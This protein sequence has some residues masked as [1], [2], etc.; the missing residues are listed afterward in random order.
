MIGQTNMK[1]II[2]IV[3]FSIFSIALVAQPSSDKL[4]RQGASFHDK[5]RYSEAISCYQQ[6]LKVNPSSMSAV[7]E[8][9]LSYLKMEDYP[10][11]IKHSTQ[12]INVGFKPLLVDAYVVK[13]TA[14]AAQ[15]KLDEAISLFT[16]AIS[17][18]GSEY[19]LHYNLGLAYYNKGNTNQALLHLR[20]AVERDATHSGAFLAYAYALNDADKWVQSFYAF[21]FFLLLEPNTKRSADAFREMYQIL[22][23]KL[24]KTDSKLKPEDGV[25]RLHLYSLIDKHRPT[26]PT[27]TAKYSFFEAASKEIFTYMTATNKEINKGVLWEFFVPIY[28]EMLES[29][30]FNTYCRYVSVAYFPESLQWWE[31]NKNEVDNFIEWFEQ[32]KSPDVEDDAFFEGEE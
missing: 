13:G 22:D 19:L 12:V 27:R 18:C 6:A 1:K 24:D 17:Q 21:H 8:M 20:K 15:N 23:T 28:S 11:A 29:G 16:Q 3:L 5:G 25:N 32:G 31:A 2:G 26:L 10:N 30:H 14:L 4:I 7:Y 9:S